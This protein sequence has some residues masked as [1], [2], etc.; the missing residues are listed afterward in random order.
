MY[1]NGGLPDPYDLGRGDGAGRESKIERD[2]KKSF[3]AGL[4]VL[5]LFGSRAALA[6]DCSPHCDFWHYYG[7]YDF[8]YI[9]PGLLGYPICD[10]QGN[11]APHLVYTQPDHRTGRITVTVRPRGTMKR[12]PP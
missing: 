6:E 12:P 5:I 4:C 9:R 11:C 3:A 8:S 7:P 10:R 2:M 1:R